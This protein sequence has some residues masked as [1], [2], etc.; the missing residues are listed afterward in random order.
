MASRVIRGYDRTNSMLDVRT[1]KRGY[2]FLKGKLVVVRS[3][4]LFDHSRCRTK[5]IG[6]ILEFQRCRK[7]LSSTLAGSQEHPRCDYRR[8]RIYFFARCANSA[9]NPIFPRI[10]ELRKERL[11][12]RNT[13]PLVVSVRYRRRNVGSSQRTMSTVNDLLA[14]QRN[15]ESIVLFVNELEL[16]KDGNADRS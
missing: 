12:N 1:A 10:G 3:F 9:A 14:V 13:S 5:D 2:H 11:A 7:N 16:V 15:K 8:S 4:A 6:G